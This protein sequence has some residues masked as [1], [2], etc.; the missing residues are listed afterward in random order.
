VH[1]VNCTVTDALGDSASRT[2]KV[3]V[4]D[5]PPVVDA[6]PDRTVDPGRIT[7]VATGKAVQTT[8]LTY[9]WSV[10][11]TPPEEVF[12][13][14]PNQ[15]EAAFYARK[16]GAYTFRASVSTGSMQA[17]D[18]VV[19]TVRNLAPW[20]DVGATRDA[21]QGTELALDGTA[22]RDPNGDALTYAWSVV[23]GEGASIDAATDGSTDGARAQLK[24]SLAGPV[25][26]RLTV[27]DGTLSSS[28]DL[29]VRVAASPGGGHPPVAVAGADQRVLT[30]ATVQ[31]DGSASWDPDGDSLTFAWTQLS[32]PDTPALSGA[33][34]P[35]AAF[36]PEVAG[37]YVLALAVS[38]GVYTVKDTVRVTVQDAAGNGRPLALILANE[39]TV[40][41]GSDADL[42]GSASRDP[43]GNALSFRWRQT[44]GP[45]VGLHGADTAHL[46]FTATADATLRFELVVN[47]GKID[48]LPAAATVHV[49]PATAGAP[50]AKATGPAAGYVGESL[51]LDGSASSDP[52]G[53]QL[54]YAW[55]QL[56]G[57]DAVL[58]GAD[59]PVATFVP[60][61]KGTYVL[62]LVVSNGVALSAPADVTVQVE[63]VPSLEGG[64]SCGAGSAGTLALL[65]LAALLRR[66]RR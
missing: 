5:V 39:V 15:A 66:R 22:S 38:D 59:K 65:G 13:E 19:V 40:V 47:D 16:A 57:P 46:S 23:S 10:V 50:V 1:S 33:D 44:A 54:A 34:T 3:A 31:L 37:D 58:S 56:S 14:G 35:T 52:G 62:R 60:V 32:G 8:H 30:G 6:G 41:T 4:G 64:C 43:D 53:H 27:S 45:A 63:G 26:A 2:V 12:L 36:A 24:L 17:S 49:T 11:G 28:N 9:F 55:S 42:D 7:L 18:D 51:T 29:L 20:A 25:V 48:S 21:V 61:Q